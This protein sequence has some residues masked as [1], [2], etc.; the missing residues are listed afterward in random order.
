MSQGGEAR[1]Y[2]DHRHDG[3]AAG[4]ILTGLG[5]G[6]AGHFGLDLRG[7]FSETFGLRLDAQVGSSQIVGLSLLIRQG[8]Q[9]MKRAWLSGMRGVFGRQGGRRALAVLGPLIAPGVGGVVRP[10][11]GR[12]CRAGFGSWSDHD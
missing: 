4:L 12:T 3:Y 11:G 2:Y 8:N 5:S 10:A 1:V 9:Q 6:V 7:Y